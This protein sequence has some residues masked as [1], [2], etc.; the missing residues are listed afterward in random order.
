MERQT[1]CVTSPKDVTF[2]TGSTWQ[3]C[4][5]DSSLFWCHLW[6]AARV[7]AMA[8]LEEKFKIDSESKILKNETNESKR[9]AV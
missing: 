2:V 1:F 6:V 3:I 9:E 4:P 8:V 5:L 7:A